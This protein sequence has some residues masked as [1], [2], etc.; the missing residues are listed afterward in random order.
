MTKFLVL[1]LLIAAGL[2]SCNP[3]VEE[4]A[5]VENIPEETIVAPTLPEQEIHRIDSLLQRVLKNYRFNGNTLIAYKGYPIFRS[6]SGFKDL[7][8]R[9]TLNI[10]TAFQIASVS[11][12]FTAMSILMLSE[13]GYFC[14]DDTLIQFIPEFP[15]NDVTI[16]QLLLHTSGM[17]NY[18]YYVDHQWEENKPIT[19]E[20]VLQLLIDNDPKLNF[21]PGR[22]HYYNNTG[23]AILALL[24]ERV[25]GL[26]FHQFLEE[27]IFRPLKMD[28]TFAWNQQAIDT[29]TNIATGFTRRGWRYRKFEHNPLDEV[30]GDKSVYTT[31]DDL[32][33]WDQALYTDDLICDSLLNESFTEGMT[34]RKRTFKYGYGWRLK[35][36]NGKR[37]I[38]HNGLWNGFTSS[39]TRYVDDSLTIIV[40][41]NTNA[42]V[43]SIVRQLHSVLEK[44][45][46]EEELFVDN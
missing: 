32:L 19:N 29:I 28:H 2:Y 30:L 17:Q 9:D 24:V 7:N 14:L 40:L 34:S 16:K 46:P 25:S 10:N 27:N 22:K 15:F 6:S 5:V 20:D 26:P 42:A 35:E 45:I 1:L 11:K 39:L 43:A 41:N 8:T 33:R 4:N 37:V 38:Y 12:T 13:R 21:R 3:P 18:M 44:E 23:Y 31:V 36:K